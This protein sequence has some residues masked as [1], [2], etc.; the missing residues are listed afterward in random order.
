[1]KITETL[2]LK[3]PNRQARLNAWFTL[4]GIEKRDV[5]RAMDV[6]PQ[7]VSAIISGSCAPGHRIEQLIALGVPR[8]LLPEP[9]DGKPGPKSKIES[10]AQGDAA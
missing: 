3:K 6:S 8:R 9:S 7:M 10:A 2:K 4:F 1:M 5:A